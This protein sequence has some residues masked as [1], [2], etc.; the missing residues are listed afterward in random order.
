MATKWSSKSCHWRVKFATE[1][2]WVLRSLNDL[3][4]LCGGCGSGRSAQ[5]LSL[6]NLEGMEGL[7]SMGF[8]K[9]LNKMV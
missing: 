3:R 8:V 7:N 5:T 6:S 1:A 2:A 9:I 4:R